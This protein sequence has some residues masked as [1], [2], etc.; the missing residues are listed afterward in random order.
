MLAQLA[1]N[2]LP[3]IVVSEDPDSCFRLWRE[4][5]C[6]WC[7]A[8]CRAVPKPRVGGESGSHNGCVVL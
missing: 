1:H 3:A 6:G 8:V 7:M 5:F 2:V 4:R